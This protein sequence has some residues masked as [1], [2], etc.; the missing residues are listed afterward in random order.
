M[1]PARDTEI[2]SQFLKRHKNVFIYVASLNITVLLSCLVKEY[3]ISS[4][5][6]LVYDQT[7]V[8]EFWQDAHDMPS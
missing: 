7:G 1:V 2:I 4:D 3:T 6:N 5:F 8:S